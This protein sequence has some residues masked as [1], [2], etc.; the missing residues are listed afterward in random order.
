M[1]DL[2]DKPAVITGAASGIGRALAQRLT[3]EGCRLALIDVDAEGLAE[4]R[5]SVTSNSRPF[6]VVA[7]IALEADVE[8]ARQAIEDSVGPVDVLCNNAGVGFAGSALEVPDTIWNW[9]FGVNMLGVLHCVRAFV[10]SMVERNY[11]Y[12]MNVASV[13]G[14][15]APAGMAAYVASKHAVVG[16]TESLFHELAAKNANVGVSVACPGMVNTA[17]S[18]S[19]RNWPDHLGRRPDDFEARSALALQ[20]RHQRALARSMSAEAAA[21]RIVDGMLRRQFWIFTDEAYDEELAKHSDL[22]Q[23]PTAPKYM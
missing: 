20:K 9:M 22:T 21:D 11:G 17:I 4:T 6:V 1:S 19:G 16:Y 7:D 13:A 10:P 12:V 2:A 3:Q 8:A 14:L 5:E 23:A 18:H 15:L